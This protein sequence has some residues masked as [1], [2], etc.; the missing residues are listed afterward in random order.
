M[1]AHHALMGGRMRQGVLGPICHVQ[2]ALLQIEIGTP[3]AANAANAKENPMRLF[4]GLLLVSA[5]ACLVPAQGWTDRTAANGPGACVDAS[6]A[7]DPVHGYSLMVRRTNL[8]S[9][10]T[11]SWDGSQWT[12]LG[13]APTGLSGLVWHEATQEVVGLAATLNT[14]GPVAY[15]LHVWTGSSWAS[16]LSSPAALGLHNGRM[17]SAYDPVRQESVFRAGVLGTNGVV[18]VYTGTGLIT[19]TMASGP[20]NNG[21][22]EAMAWDPIVQKVVLARNDWTNV[23]IGA[24]WLGI[25]VV[26][27][28]EWSGFGWNLRYPATAPGLLGCMATDIQRQRVVIFDGDHP[29]SMTTGGSQPNH[30]WTISAGQTTRLSTLLAPEPRQRAAMAFDSARGV[31]VMFGGIISTYSVQ[32][33]DTWEFDLGPVA[34]F[35]TYG[36]GCA[37]SRG[38]PEVSAPLG[39]LPRIGTTFNVQVSNLPFTGPVF[40]G[41][42]FSD[43]DYGGTPLPLDLSTLGAPSC[44]LFQ[45]MDALLSLANVVGTAAWSLTVPPIPGGEFFVQAF[46]YDPPA[47]AFGYTASNAARAVLGLY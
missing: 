4:S 32:Y 27:F 25:P 11:W 40:L 44:H 30:T 9:Y 43:S 5:L 35:A 38:I 39:S 28:Y 23:L 14:Q 45:S 29:T 33:S 6:M 20:F 31:M 42:G 22:Q 13:P 10:D 3:S 37:G 18:L 16:T 34:Q 46:A 12:N 15:Q 36:Q 1:V 7:F 41:V 19:R 47:N 21:E 8:G 2:V 24:T 26:R 17:A